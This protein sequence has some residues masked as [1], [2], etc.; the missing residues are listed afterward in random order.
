MLHQGGAVHLW[1]SIGTIV[2][3]KFLDNGA[4]VRILRLRPPAPLPRTARNPRSY[5]LDLCAPP[6]IK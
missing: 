6:H 1:F 3:T 4:Y 2:R 5:T